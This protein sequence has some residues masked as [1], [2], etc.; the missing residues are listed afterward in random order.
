MG[1]AVE[2]F[3][4]RR[5]HPR[6]DTLLSVR[7]AGE[8]AWFSTRDVSAGGM[9]L[10]ADR[11]MR[12]GDRLQLELLLP[13]SSWLPLTGKVAWSMR[14]DVGSSAAYEVGLRFLDLS[15]DDLTRLR[16]VLP[17]DPNAPVADGGVRNA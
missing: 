12:K 6:Q 11:A 5:A 2:S 7:L 4:N 9:R 14:M 1:T 16:P 13:D 3:V 17:P 10:L 15:E 8:D